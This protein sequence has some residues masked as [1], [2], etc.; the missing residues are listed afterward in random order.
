MVNANIKRIEIK[1]KIL[2]SHSV[3]LKSYFCLQS[4][5]LLS[6]NP[7]IFRLARLS[8]MRWMREIR[9]EKFLADDAHVGLY[10]SVKCVRLVKKGK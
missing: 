10:W 3:L 2:N 8:H 7:S 6:K 5:P 4:F 1:V 9:A